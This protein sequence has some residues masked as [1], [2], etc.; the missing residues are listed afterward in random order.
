MKRKIKGILM[1]V[2]FVLICILIFYNVCIPVLANKR[3]V[4][5]PY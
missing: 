5:S 4:V 3:E 2:F 1:L